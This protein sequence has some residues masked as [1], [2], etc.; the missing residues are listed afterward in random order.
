MTSSSCELTIASISALHR[1]ADGPVLFLDPE[2]E[3]LYR[4]GC[5]EERP[6]RALVALGAAIRHLDRVLTSAV[7]RRAVL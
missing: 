1:Q 4:A 2:L 3:A 7:A 6:A 5:V